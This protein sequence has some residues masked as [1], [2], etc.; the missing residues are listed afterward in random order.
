MLFNPDSSKQVQEILF[1]WKN[2]V[3]N[4]G[5]IWLNNVIIN[6]GNVLKHLGLFFNV[7]LDFI[8]HIN[9]QIKKNK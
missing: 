8:E 5:S 4:H 3:T 1:S 7:R 2:R 6:M 9:A